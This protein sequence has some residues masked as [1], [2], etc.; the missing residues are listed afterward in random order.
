MIKIPQNIE[1]NRTVN[2]AVY[3][4]QIAV[5]INDNSENEFDKVKKANDF[6]AVLIRYDAAGF[7][8]GNIPDQSYQNVLKTRL[9]VCEGYA[10]L[11]KK[12]CDELKIPCV[13]VHGYA[14]GVGS[15]PA[16]A[17]RP[18][19]SNHAWNIVT[20][21]NESYLIDCTWNSGYMDGM[22]SKQK[23]TT[24]WLFCK[25]E[26]FIYTHF[27]SNVNQQ[28]LTS[29][30]TA[31]QFSALPFF[32]P[33]FFDT[34]NLS[35]KLPKINHAGGQFS[36]EYTSR[37]DNYFSF[38]VNEIKTG[39]A[40]QNR[41]FIQSNESGNTAFFSFP[42]AGQYIVNVFLFQTGAKQGSIC[43]EFIVEASSASSVQYPVIYSSSAKNLQII[44]PIEMPLE[45]GKT[46]TFN[47]KAG[48]KKNV[49]IIYGSTFVQ[50]AKGED[51]V[52]T[53][54]FLVPS[55]INSLSLGIADSERG[56]Y[57]TIA[58]YQVK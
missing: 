16:A 39:K 58:T 42:S 35:V 36:F 27:P 18:N 32:R 48:N 52:F 21:Y 11:F 14:R 33:G 46:Y 6:A 15:S 41:V 28:L 8:A 56:R 55:N 23:Y 57:E 34:A 17:E 12:L 50:L 49:A 25:P 20:I 26:H 30:L 44:S 7:W 37:N 43:G 4:K 31:A 53:F 1:R 9:A 29:P 2:P 13:I 24:E 54:E 51:D 22:V 19:E 47:I 3:I 10:N 45:R 38:Q 5:L 40:I